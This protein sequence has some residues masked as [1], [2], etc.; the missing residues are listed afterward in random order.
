[1]EHRPTQHEGNYN[2][3]APKRPIYEVQPSSPG[4]NVPNS[5]ASSRISSTP[6]KQVVQVAAENQPS[7]RVVENKGLT[8]GPQFPAAWEGP[9]DERDEAMTTARTREIADRSLYP[10]RREPFHRKSLT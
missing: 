1:M 3:Q 5:R 9:P 4:A 6:S 10:T 7:P 8:L 2:S